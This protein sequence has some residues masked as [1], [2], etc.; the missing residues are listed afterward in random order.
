MALSDGS[1]NFLL[2][3]AHLIYTQ[4]PLGQSQSMTSGI[5]RVGHQEN[6]LKCFMILCSVHISE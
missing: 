5:L 6:V 1:Y 4:N 2:G 3:V